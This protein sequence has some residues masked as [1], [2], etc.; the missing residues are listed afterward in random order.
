[1]RDLV[2]AKRIA[3]ALFGA[4]FICASTARAQNVSEVELQNFKPAM[5]SAGQKSGGKE[6]KET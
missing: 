5:D 1:M 6:K 3:L 2:R 4:S